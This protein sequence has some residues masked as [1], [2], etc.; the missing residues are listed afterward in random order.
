MVFAQGVAVGLG[1]MFSVT[2]SA[3]FGFKYTFLTIGLF[4]CSWSIGYAAWCG[5]KENVPL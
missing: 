2:L 1:M 5:T 3:M 4:I